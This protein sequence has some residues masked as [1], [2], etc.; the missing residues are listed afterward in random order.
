MS[1]KRILGIILVLGG[2]ALLL[3][4]N[5]IANQVEQG[6]EQISSAQKK[7]DQGNSL[8]S[9]SPYTKDVG[10]Q[11]TG[12]AQKKIDAGQQEVIQYETLAGQ[13]K[14]GGIVVLVVG[15]LFVIFGRK[16]KS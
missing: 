14:I 10:E 9:M 3:V 1:W 11:I 5:Y 4:S 15:L 6:K 16:R 13:L 2:V 7:V 8:F 12:S